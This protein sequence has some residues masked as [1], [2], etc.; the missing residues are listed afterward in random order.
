MKEIPLSNGGVALVD[1]EDYERVASGPKWQYHALRH[2]YRTYGYAQRKVCGRT[3]LLHRLILNAPRG[4]IVDHINGDGLNNTRANLRI[5][6]YAQNTQNRR[7]SAARASSRFIGVY[8]HKRNRAWAVEVGV[9]LVGYFHDEEA[10][11]RA[12]DKTARKRYGE[13]ARLNFPREGEQS[14]IPNDRPTSA[15]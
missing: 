14:A 13:F 3:Q 11:G 15:A 1:D 2:R 7:K 10:A 6:S 8:W 5:C 4:A 9:E 12:Y